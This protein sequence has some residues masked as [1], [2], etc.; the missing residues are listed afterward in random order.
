LKMTDTSA[1]CSPDFLFNGLPTKI[2]ELNIVA[3]KVTEG[4]MYGFM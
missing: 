3:C 1:L 2:N 4:D